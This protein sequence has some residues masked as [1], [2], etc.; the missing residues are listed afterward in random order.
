M[1]LFEDAISGNVSALK[2]RS[3]DQVFNYVV[4]DW[5]VLRFL[6]RFLWLITKTSGLV[7]NRVQ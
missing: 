7:R 6:V 5:L 1:K 3:P 4:R 2:T